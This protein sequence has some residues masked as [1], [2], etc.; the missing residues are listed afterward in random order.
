MGFFMDGRVDGRIEDHLGEA[1]P[2]PQINENN[3]T[4]V[5]STQDPS[6]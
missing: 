4:V 5:P 1:F 2:I 3:P 6:H